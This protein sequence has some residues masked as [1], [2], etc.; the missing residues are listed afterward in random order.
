MERWELI[1]CFTDH[2]WTTDYVDVCPDTDSENDVHQ[3][4]IEKYI[5]ETKETDPEIAYIGTYYEK[6]KRCL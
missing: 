1:I 2:S 4:Y 3:A 6:E 5:E